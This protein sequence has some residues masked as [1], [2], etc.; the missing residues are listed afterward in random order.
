MLDSV[1]KRRQHKGSDS[2]N[3]TQGVWSGVRL[4][5]ASGPRRGDIL[6]ALKGMRERLSPFV[7]IG[8]EDASKRERG[9]LNLSRTKKKKEKMI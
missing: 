2:A 1:V 4:A 8:K 7:L 9:E 6:R 3:S 5:S